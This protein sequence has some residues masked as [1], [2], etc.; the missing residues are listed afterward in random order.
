MVLVP[1]A[2]AVDL[3]VPTCV[4]IPGKVQQVP[5]KLEEYLVVD[6]GAPPPEDSPI[7]GLKESEW[8][9]VRKAAE[10]WQK[11]AQRYEGTPR[12]QEHDSDRRAR[13]AHPQSRRTNPTLRFVQLWSPWPALS[14]SSLRVCA[15]LSRFKIRFRLENGLFRRAN[16]GFET[17]HAF[18]DRLPRASIPCKTATT[19]F[20]HPTGP[21]R[22]PGTS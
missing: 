1:D 2:P 7:A 3:P 4:T 5:S 18:G 6:G 21:W 15:G 19:E 10:Q 12:T 8:H 11:Q 13:D 20:T 17:P 16:P 9:V 14:V 22:R